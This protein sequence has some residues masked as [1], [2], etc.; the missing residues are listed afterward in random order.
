[1][2]E[3]E[4]RLPVEDWSVGPGLTGELDARLEEAE[5]L[6]KMDV[7]LARAEDV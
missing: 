1:M 5:K 3:V 2:V 4:A 7:G 6:G